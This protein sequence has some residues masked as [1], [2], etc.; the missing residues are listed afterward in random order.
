[1]SWKDEVFSSFGGPIE[2]PSFDS[3]STPSFPPP[4]IGLTASAPCATSWHDAV[5]IKGSAKSVGAAA[6][7]TAEGSTGAVIFERACE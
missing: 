7:G 2:C 3:Q 5:G 1:V 4:P 6:A